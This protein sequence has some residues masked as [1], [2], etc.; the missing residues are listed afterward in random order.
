MALLR[1]YMLCNHH[2]K[3]KILVQSGREPES[4]LQVTKVEIHKDEKFNCGVSDKLYRLL[5]KS[6]RKK[7]CALS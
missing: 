6:P 2:N 5:D 7:N 1:K 4:L 3:D